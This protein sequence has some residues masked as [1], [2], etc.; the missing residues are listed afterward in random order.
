[1]SRNPEGRGSIQFRYINNQSL[2]F[3][4]TLKNFNSPILVFA[5]IQIEK[6]FYKLGFSTQQK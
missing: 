5:L 4:F 3:T 2:L 1:M 6:W